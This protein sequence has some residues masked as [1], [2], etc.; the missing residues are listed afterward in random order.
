MDLYG[1]ERY[2]GRWVPEA[3]IDLQFLEPGIYLL[4]MQQAGNIIAREKLIILR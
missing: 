1:K 3:A 2:S 4:S